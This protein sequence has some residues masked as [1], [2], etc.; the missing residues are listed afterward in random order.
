MEV[1]LG[2][3]DLLVGR[4]VWVR[5][6]TLV[7]GDPFVFFFN[8]LHTSLHQGPRNTYCQ[9]INYSNTAENDIDSILTT[10]MPG[11]YRHTIVTCTTLY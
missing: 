1:C 3:C 10:K 11:S 2:S 9:V 5:A 8:C 4:L 7:L 6:L